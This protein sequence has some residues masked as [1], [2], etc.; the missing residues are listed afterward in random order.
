MSNETLNPE[1]HP[2]KP[3][4][5]PKQV[6]IFV[7]TTPHRVAKDEISFE[8]VV[9]LA[10]PTTPPG[11]NVGFTVLYQR[12]HGNKDGTLVPGQVVKVKD[13]MIFDVTPTDLS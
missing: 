4:K 7:N 1:T 13:G 5:D 10:F 11:S 12:G 8:E 2:D 6:T 3:D 9:K